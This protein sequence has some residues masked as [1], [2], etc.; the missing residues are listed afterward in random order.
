M[1][2]ATPL[3]AVLTVAAGVL[4][5]VLS[6][7]FGIG[8]AAVS[9]PAIRAL[10]VSAVFAVGTTLPSILPSAA[11]GSLGYARESLVSW[12]V[13]GW[14]APAGVAGAVI[15][16]L[17]SERVPGEG[18]W[19]MIATA[20]LLAYTSVRMARSPT[21]ERAGHSPEN[22][23][24]RDRPAVL[25]SLGAAAGLLSG[26][27]GVGGGTIMVPGFSELAR[28][29]L[30]T[31]IACSLVCVGVL[32]VPATLT[33]WS[34]GDIDWRT[35]GLLSLGVVPGARLGAALAIRARTRR[36]RLAV[37]AFLGVVAVVYGVG[38]ALAL[39]R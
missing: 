9:T 15:G 35:A 11:T 5:G 7:A 6:G 12:R 16:S 8:G 38:E 29:P 4:T 30:K 34:L 36:L 18:H 39:T 28:I 32:A 14:A 3:N 20:V 10:G 13:V 24:R 1:M 25:L 2:D 31:A 27:L 37:A 22:E 21:S 17:L 26:L 19:L 33:H 23:R